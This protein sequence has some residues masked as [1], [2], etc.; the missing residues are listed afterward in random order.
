MRLD[1]KMK[2]RGERAAC[3][4]ESAPARPMPVDWHDCAW[5]PQITVLA[6]PRAA[7]R[8]VTKRLPATPPVLH[9]PRR[10][11]IY[12]KTMKT[13]LPSS[14]RRRAGFTLVEL[15][16]VIAII[17]ILAGM[18][19][20]VLSAVK[21]KAKKAQA[22]IEAQSIATAIEGYD[23]A[24]GRFPASHAAQLAANNALGDF[25]YGTTG[26]A[27]ATFSLPTTSYGINA[28]NSDVMAILMNITVY[29]GTST[30]TINTNSQSNPQQTLFL[31]A[32]MSG[33]TSSPGVGTDLVY[34]DP[35]GNPYIISMDLNYDEQCKD[36]LYSLAAV[37]SSTGA[38]GGSGFNGLVEPA[39]TANDYQFHGKVMV[40]SAGPDKNTDSGSA[41]GPNAGANKDNVLSWQQ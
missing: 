18:L 14:R 20:P 41:S 17:A 38:D 5:S 19:L 35:W 13:L 33:D 7:R 31:N 12:F 1:K 26:V 15:L 25:T 23:S 29:P 30:P 40:W 6:A 39:N 27:N 16:V 2:S 32:K 3:P 22:K 28:N 34:R 11:P 21:T 24:Y 8:L 37:S 36:A 4:D 10:N 9:T